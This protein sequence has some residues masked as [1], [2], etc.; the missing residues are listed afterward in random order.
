MGEQRMIVKDGVPYDSND[1]TVSGNSVDAGDILERLS[2]LFR[3]KN[4]GYG[5]TYLTQGQIMTALFPDGVILKT[6]ED[7]NRFYVVD[8]MVMKFQRYCR[9]FVEGGHLDSIHDTSI[10]GAMLA[11]LDENILIRKEKKI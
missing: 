4:K 3:K 5:A 2:E 10:Y 11:E 9:K 8:E 1:F 6:V 7:F